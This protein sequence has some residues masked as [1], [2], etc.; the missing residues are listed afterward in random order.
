MSR[1]PDFEQLVGA[2]ELAPDELERLRG[3]HDLL[4]AA[5][6]PPELPPALEQA[7]DVDAPVTLLPRRRRA[8]L[9]LLAAAL[10]L[11][12]FGAGYLVS[13]RGDG[14]TGFKADTSIPP[15][16][17][18]GTVAAPG[19]LASIRLGPADDGGNWPMLF[20][21]RGL[22]Q[23]PPN[24][25]YELYLSRGGKPVAS[26][27]TFRV[28]GGTTTV[29]LN[30]PYKLRRFSGWIVTMHAKSAGGDRKLLTT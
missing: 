1:R 15:I 19:A 27:G 6:P 21:V 5:G 2:D 8:V 23:L 7:P 4:I 13:G 9:A 10:A 14:N 17:M 29:L 20:T 30:A 22:K 3:V 12:A 16:P 18:H 11:A 28:H 26:C 25:Y 24:Q